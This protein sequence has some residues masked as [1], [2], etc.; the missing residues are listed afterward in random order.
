MDHTFNDILFQVFIT[1]GCIS[2]H[3]H[4]THIPSHLDFHNTYHV[5]SHLAY[6]TCSLLRH[7]PEILALCYTWLA[8]LLE[9]HTMLGCVDA[10]L[11]VYSSVPLSVH[12][13]LWQ[14]SSQAKPC[15]IRYL[16]LYK[17]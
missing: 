2:L 12:V 16:L 13:K 7:V 14:I 10:L 17:S 4:G 8:R 15:L 1:R 9:E 11:E 5:P 6:H 3:T